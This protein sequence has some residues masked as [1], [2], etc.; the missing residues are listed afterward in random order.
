MLMV[1]DTQHIN[2]A[3]TEQRWYITVRECRTLFK[4]TLNYKEK[5]I[6]ERRENDRREGQR[7]AASATL[8]SVRKQG[9]TG[10]PG[11][12]DLP[13]SSC[14]RKSSS[15]TS[16]VKPHVKQ[17]DWEE[18]RYILYVQACTAV[19]LSLNLSLCLTSGYSPSISLIGSFK[20]AHAKSDVAVYNVLLRETVH[21]AS[22]PLD[23]SRCNWLSKCIF[24]PK[25]AF[26]VLWSFQIHCALAKHLL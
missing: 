6:V 25:L 10:G 19:S 8:D 20:P 24:S 16:Q 26:H 4:L 11:R 13:G 5:E 9:L 2:P 21:G 15:G 22:I 1:L 12:I 17:S 23:E 7:R 14:Q 18:E 3:R